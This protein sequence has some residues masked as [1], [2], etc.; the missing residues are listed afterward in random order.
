MPLWESIV[1]GPVRS[2][3]LGSSLG[4]N[5][6]P[7]TKKI[8]SFDCAYC[9]CGWTDEESRIFK[10]FY[11]FSI[12]IEALEKKL[13]LCRQENIAIDSIT[14][15]G[16][17]EPTMHPDFGKIVDELIV[18]R[19]RY[20]PD[21]DIT[22]LS[23]STQLNKEG[24]R[25][26]LQKIENPILKLDA[27]TEHFYQR[28]NRPLFPISLTEIVGALKSFNGHLIIQ[29]LFVKKVTENEVFDNSSGEELHQLLEHIR[30]ICPR[31][32]MLYSLDRATP[33]QQLIKIE[34][35]KLEEIA[36]EIKQMGILTEV[37]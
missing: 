13:I 11:P 19:N 32:V 23:N 14:F 34:K 17:G 5:L 25:K 28:V 31:K 24:V 7:T 10:D 22:C 35:E 2:R 26:A 8:C 3:R 18:L 15:A 30:T 33:D 27:G 6:L 12:V 16:N 21:A 1:F 36:K 20:Y 37:Y 4:I 29:T 9:E